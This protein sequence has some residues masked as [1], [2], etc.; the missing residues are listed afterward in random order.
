MAER[1]QVA[2]YLGLTT[3]FQVSYKF[4]ILITGQ[5]I[6]RRK[7]APLP[8]PQSVIHQVEYMAI[9]EYLNEDVIL[10]ERNRSTL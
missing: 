1:L 10:S 3:Y 4:I 2:I 7:F 8:M 9:K 6:T 5:R